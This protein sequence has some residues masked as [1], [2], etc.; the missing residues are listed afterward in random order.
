MSKTRVL[1]VLFLTQPK[2]MICM[3][4]IPASAV[5]LNCSIF[6]LRRLT[7]SS[8]LSQSVKLEMFRFLMITVASLTK[9]AS[10]SLFFGI[11]SLDEM[12]FS[13]AIG[14]EIV[15]G[16]LL[17]ERCQLG[18][19][20]WLLSLFDLLWR[21]I[22]LITELA[23]LLVLEYLVGVRLVSINKSK[24][25]KLAIIIRS[26]LI[27]KWQGKDRSHKLSLILKSPVMIK[28]LLML[29]SVFLRYFNA[30]WEE[31]E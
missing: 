14:I 23:P 20:K 7:I 9:V 28:R 12:T 24:L 22:R 30:E 16:V 5:D 18:W 3:R 17:D 25:N 11:E 19:I 31:S 15:R 29:T 4:V 8:S 13:S 6:N 1:V 27:D 21:N 2:C 26:L 10:S